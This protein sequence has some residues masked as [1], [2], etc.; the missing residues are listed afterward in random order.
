M[1]ATPT[2]RLYGL[3][4]SVAVKPPVQISADV[5]VITF[6]EQTITTTTFTGTRT[7]TTEKGMR[8]LL[9]NQA[10]PIDNG[11]WEAMPATWRRA[12]DF[13]GARDSV[14]GTLVFSVYGDCWQVEAND[15]VRIG[16][17]PIH[18][19]STYPFSE[20]GN[21]FQRS[22][23]VPEPFIKELPV[24]ADR[25]NKQLGFD[26]SGDPVFLDPAGTGLWGYVLIDSFEVGALLTERFQALRWESNGEYY[27]WDGSLPK[28]VP[29]GSTPLSSGGVGPGAWVGIG[30]ASLRAILATNQGASLI[31]S[32]PGSTVQG[33][34][35]RLD[36][37]AFICPEMY[38]NGSETD[39]TAAFRQALSDAKAQKKKFVATGSYVL[40]A[41]A[42]NPIKIEVDA[43]M[44]M[45]TVTCSTYQSGDVWLLNTSLFE[46]PQLESDVTAQFSGVS[47]LR[48]QTNIPVTGLQGCIILDSTDVVMIR[49]NGGSLTNQLKT[50]VHEIDPDGTLRYRNYYTYTSP[51]SVYYKPFTNTL[52]IQMPKL[53][54]DGARINNIVLCSRNNT[55]INGNTV[56]I[57]NNGS[58]RQVV[59]FQRCSRVYVNNVYM[60]PVG[61]LEGTAPVSPSGRNEVG[62][63]ILTEKCSDVTMENC[64][65]I[66]GWGGFDGNKTRN[67]HINRCDFPGIGGHFSMSDIYVNECTVRYHCASQ[68][69]GEWV[70]TNCKHLGLLGKDV[71]EFFSVKRDYMS[72]WDG[73][74]RVEGL[75]VLLP[76]TCTGYFVVSSLEPKYNGNFIATSPDVVIR[77]VSLDLSNASALV[78]L[79]ILDLGV[80]AGSNF[81]QYMILPSSH[82]IENVK[83]VGTRS[84]GSSLSAS[85]VYNQRNYTSLT[86]AQLSTIVGRGKYKL[87]VKDVDLARLGNTTQASNPRYNV[88]TFKFTTYRVPQDVNI[89]NSYNCVPYISGWDDMLVRV[90]NQDM[91]MGYIDGAVART[92]ASYNRI[93]FNNC[94]IYGPGW[95]SSGGQRT[96][97][98]DFTACVFGWLSTLT[99]TT[100]TSNTSIGGY[101]G[102]A[103]SSNSATGKLSGCA[104]F[105]P[106]NSFQQVDATFKARIVAG[107][108]NSGIYLI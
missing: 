8:V 102:S 30:D 29:A 93:Y 55:V 95:G 61:Y 52:S 33:E 67:V 21:L 74:I 50:E 18:F 75:R 9:T 96:G 97:I 65:N 62:Y 76:S 12:P 40:S 3:T 46:I 107:Y 31:G 84:Y 6:G 15:P 90:S 66:N 5:N 70:A 42:S 92:A 44:S 86:A 71:L 87:T 85:V 58:A 89:D 106:S 59:N 100:E 79:R 48:G 7:V 99:G 17:D 69:W 41:S 16:Y 103:E 34:L 82:Y 64:C 23:R 22:L 32:S 53:V 105:L 4:T 1:P 81:E 68:G 35:D 80:S 77:D 37:S 11:I 91:A 88:Q 56:E 38:L 36:K 26:G 20:N 101:L 83:I 24:A 28:E 72:S 73:E 45:A 47:Y 13:D 54:L 57:K 39:H 51:P 78:D 63:F 94:R 60:S 2:D 14:N 19:R 43:D 10:D 108:T 104:I 27:R 25:A 98:F 49:N